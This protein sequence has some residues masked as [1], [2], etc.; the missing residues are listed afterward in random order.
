MSDHVCC[1]CDAAKADVATPVPSREALMELFEAAKV[2]DWS[3]DQREA[4]DRF[5]EALARC[6]REVEGGGDGDA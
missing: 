5:F 1:G 2:Y 4:G 3:W 6:Q